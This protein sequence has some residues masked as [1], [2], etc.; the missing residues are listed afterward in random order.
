MHKRKA[1]GGLPRWVYLAALLLCALLAVGAVLFARAR[2]APTPV[3]TE[4]TQ[5]MLL[6]RDVSTLS[7]IRV[8][9]RD[10]G[11]YTLVY[12][13]GAL[14]VRGQSAFVLSDSARTE[15]LEMAASIEA[16]G[17]VLADAS[18][19]AL[20]DFGLDPPVVT[21][22]FAYADGT[23]FTLRLGDGIPDD[24]PH[25]YGMVEGD[26]ALYEMPTF[27]K[28]AL[29]VTLQSLHAVTQ[30]GIK[31]ELADEIIYT[32][33]TPFAAVRRADG[34]HMTAP[35]AYPLSQSAMDALLA[36]IDGMRFAQYVGEK[37]GAL[38]SQC[39]LDSPSSVFTLKL[40]QSV[41]SGTDEQG[42][43]LSFLIPAQTATFYAGNAFN[44]NSF[45][46]LYND[47][48]YIAT[49]LTM[50][51]IREIS[52]SDMLAQNPFNYPVNALDT[53]ETTRGGTTRSYAVR[54]VEQISE[55]G[56]LVYGEDG[57]LAYDVKVRLDGSDMDSAMFLR[58]YY[59]LVRLTPSGLLPQGYAPQGEPHTRIRLTYGDCARD[60]AFYAYDA[61]HSALCVDGVCVYY[62][63]DTWD[64]AFEALLS[65]LPL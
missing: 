20:S 3:K 1:R 54:L 14:S 10:N 44:D 57:E 61:M 56:A 34:W 49:N 58:D 63:R 35:Y 27:L 59:Q 12:Q 25:D 64:D 60:V 46:A 62:I 7:S 24:I 45:Y 18:G 22:T 6:S 52:V 38:L 51:F 37:S 50:G 47:K 40:S 30:P 17:T 23:S 13:G 53:L 19:L 39:G 42:E 15:L 33:K 65:G 32:G 11:A 48:V 28:A 26:A 21:A 41:L 8:V 9:T 31:G 4:L 16:D 2:R 43:A 5:K 36:D 55:S 29:N